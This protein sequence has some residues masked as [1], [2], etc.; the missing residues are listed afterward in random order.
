MEFSTTLNASW[1]KESGGEPRRI[2]VARVDCCVARYNIPRELHQSVSRSVKRETSN[3]SHRPTSKTRFI[4]SSFVSCDPQCEQ[5]LFLFQSCSI[6]FEL[7]TINRPSHDGLL[8]F[9]FGRSKLCSLLTLPRSSSW[10]TH[11]KQKSSEATLLKQTWK[12]RQRN[13]L[14]WFVDL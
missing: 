5:V 4:V 1:R 11:G 2:L 12:S 9:F 7:P 6:I 10:R 8:H 13:R 14:H 3:G